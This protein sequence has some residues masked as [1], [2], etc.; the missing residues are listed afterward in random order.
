VEQVLDAADTR[1]LA[2]LVLDALDLLGVIE[3][4][5]Q[6]HDPSVGIDADPTLWDR[7]VAEQV[8]LNFAH[9]ADV[10]QFRRRLLTVRDRMRQTDDLARIVVGSALDPPCTAPERRPGAVANEV[11]SPLAAARVKEEL[12][13]DARR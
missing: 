2:H 4:S 1:D 6:H 10:V 9:E 7:P 13:R 3:L 8:A 12:K 11:P 5:A